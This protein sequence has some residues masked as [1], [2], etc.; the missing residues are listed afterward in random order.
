MKE[1]SLL[2][3]CTPVR[4]AVCA[5][6]SASARARAHAGARLRP[7]GCTRLR[8]PWTPRWPCAAMRRAQA[9]GA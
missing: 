4:A 1:A 5:G 9:Q 2:A 7:T 6:A 8:G 3:V